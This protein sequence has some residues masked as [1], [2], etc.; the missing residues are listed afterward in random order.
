[1]PDTRR[2]AHDKVCG[3]SAGRGQRL[4]VRLIPGSPFKKVISFREGQRCFWQ[5]LTVSCHTHT[6]IPSVLQV[7]AGHNASCTGLSVFFAN[8][9]RAVGIPTRVA[10]TPH[11]NKGKKACPRGDADA[12]CGNHNWN[13]VLMGGQWSF[14]DTTATH[15]AFNSSWFYPGD[16]DDQ[17][18][19]TQNHSIFASSYKTTDLQ[20]HGGVFPMVW[21]WNGKVP[22][23]DVTDR[24]IH[25]TPRPE[26]RVRGHLSKHIPPTPPPPEIQTLI[27]GLYDPE[28]MVLDLVGGKIYFQVVYGP[29]LCLE[30]KIQRANLNGSQVEDYKGPIPGP[31]FVTNCTNCLWPERAVDVAAGK[32]YYTLSLGYKV[33]SV[34]RSNLDFSDDE[35]LVT[36]LPWPTNIALDA[37][38]GKVYWTDQGNP[39]SPN[40]PNSVGGSINRANLDGSKSEIIIQG[41]ASW[42]VPASCKSIVLDVES[43]KM[44]LNH[45]NFISRANLDGSAFENVVATGAGPR[46]GQIALDKKGGWLYWAQPDMGEPYDGT[47]RRV[48]FNFD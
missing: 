1:M 38:R 42:P 23:V 47:I 19:H 26:P 15:A 36:N 41:N 34:K 29:P 28:N 6:H 22:A 25:P 43:G 5:K 31:P 48:A 12:E 30:T 33:H 3:R 4:Q 35:I 45:R 24:Y 2:P 20:V 16:A 40:F 39:K 9:C 11:W 10:G 7:L 13:E 46:L 27:K 18:P 21:D 8:A 32:L 44:Y 17:V 37:T 14:I